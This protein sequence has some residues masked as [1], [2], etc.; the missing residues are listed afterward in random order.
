MSPGSAFRASTFAS[1]GRGARTVFRDGG[2]AVP[3]R[4]CSQFRCTHGR[5][6]TPNLRYH[7]CNRHPTRCRTSS[8]T[9]PAASRRRSRRRYRP[10]RPRALAPQADAGSRTAA[11]AVNGARRGRPT[12]GRPTGRTTS[13]HP[14]RCPLRAR[15][16]SPDCGSGASWG[17]GGGASRPCPCRRPS[18]ACPTGLPGPCRPRHRHPWTC[19]L[20]YS[21]IR[22]AP[23]ARAQ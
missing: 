5:L 2:A 4:Q 8:R 10:A 13:T 1:G 20:L 22:P 21:W 18:R 7:R 12:N 19:Q 23:V 11:P 9:A 16:A 3:R 6:H 15:P 14:C 17:S